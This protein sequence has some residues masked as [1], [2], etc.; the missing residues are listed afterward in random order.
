MS[1]AAERL[2][3]LGVIA[4]RARAI[5]ALAQAVCSGEVSLRPGADLESEAR[6]LGSIKGIGDWT[7][8]YLLMR[9]YG[10]PDAFPS[11]DL[12]VLGGFPTLKPRELAKLSQAWSPWRSYAVMSLWT[13]P[14]K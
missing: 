9:A 12:G 11:S 7:V 10:Y 4:Q 14:H 8:Q 13:R 2:G 1:D 3:E 5:C 6:E